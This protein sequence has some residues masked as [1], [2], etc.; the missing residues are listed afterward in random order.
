MARRLVERGVP[1]VTINYQG[2]DTHKQHFQT[3]RRKLPELDKGLATLLAGPLR[4]RPAGQHDRLVER[5]IRPHAEGPLGSALERRPRTITA[6]SSR[7]W[8]P[9]ADSRAATSSAPPTPRAKRSRSGPSIRATCSAACTNCWASIPTAKLPHPQGLAVRV[10]P[11]RRRRREDGRTAEG[12][13]VENFGVRR[14][15][16]AFCPERLDHRPEQS[17][18]P[19][20]LRV[21]SVPDWSGEKSEVASSCHYPREWDTVVDFAALVGELSLCRDNLLPVKMVF[22]GRFPE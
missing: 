12:N 7:P 14:F 15:I 3:M 20:R 13:H 18:T 4:P 5:R 17:R 10:T 22:Q 11:D 1:Y 16:A 19:F 9:A 2:W 6:R 8:W 21:P